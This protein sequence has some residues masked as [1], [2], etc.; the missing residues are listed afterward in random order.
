MNTKEFDE[1]ILRR[2]DLIETTLTQK[3]A[4]YAVGEDRLHNFNKGAA[5][6]GKSREEVLLGFAMKH[7]IS[8]TD[9]LDGINNGVLPTKAK[10]DEKLGDWISY[11][12]LL[13]ASI[14]DKM[15]KNER[16]D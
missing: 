15:N 13:E 14:V 3:A 2:L 6:T 5:F 11:M 1:V 12:C 16:V 10:L 9:I 4:E 8:L 7:W